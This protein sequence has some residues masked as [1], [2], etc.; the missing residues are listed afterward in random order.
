MSPDTLL[1]TE[2]LSLAP[3]NM[4]VS[5]DTCRLG[6]R[7]EVSLGLEKSV[8]GIGVSIG[9]DIVVENGMMTAG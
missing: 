4:S 3:L 6:L 1:E 9:M 8:L 7:V 2:S 5:V